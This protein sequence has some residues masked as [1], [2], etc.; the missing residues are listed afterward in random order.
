MSSLREKVKHMMGIETDTDTFNA[1]Q[2]AAA[3]PAPAEPIDNHKF[4]ATCE[5]KALDGTWGAYRYPGDHS[6]TEAE[7]V[8]DEWRSQPENYRNVQVVQA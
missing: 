4:T 8:A 2:D 3:A 5:F 1:D 7:R 6:R